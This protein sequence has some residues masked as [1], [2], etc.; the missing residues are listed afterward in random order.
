MTFQRNL[1][2]LVFSLVQMFIQAF[3]W[4]VGSRPFPLAINDLVLF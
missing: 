3:Q 2:Y 4:R 1:T